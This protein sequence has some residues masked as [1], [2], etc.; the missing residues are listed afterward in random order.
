MALNATVMKL[1]KGAETG[2]SALA[3]GKASQLPDCV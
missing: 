1:D 3:N 2:Y